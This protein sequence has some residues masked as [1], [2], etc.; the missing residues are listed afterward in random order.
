MPIALNVS[1]G[2]TFGMLT[3]IIEIEGHKRTGPGWKRKFI[4]LCACGNQ[5]VVYLEKLRNGMIHSCGCTKRP[6]MLRHGMYLSP[7]YHAWTAMKERCSNPTC[8]AFP[9]YGGRGIKVDDRWMRFENFFADM[10]EKPAGLSIERIDN[11]GPYAP[12]NCRW[13]TRTEQSRNTRRSRFVI[14]NGVSLCVE[15]AAKQ[16][17][18]SPH[19]IQWRAKRLNGTDQDA[20]EYYAAKRAAHD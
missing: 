4:T 15:D 16:V 11:D 17:G 9:N 14:L 13:A 19:M 1:P 5:R 8:K 2:T 7:T 20:L 10:G 6:S 18:I 3:I 12:G